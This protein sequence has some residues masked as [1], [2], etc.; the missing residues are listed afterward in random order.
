MIENLGS[1][2]ELPGLNPSLTSYLYD[3]GELIKLSE[4]SSFGKKKK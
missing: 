1:R 3:V 2:A 4:A